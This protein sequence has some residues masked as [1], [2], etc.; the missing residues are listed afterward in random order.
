MSV[1]PNDEVCSELSDYVFN[2]YIDDE[3]TLPPNIW[4]KE[5]MFDPR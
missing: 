2:N 5:P 4:A 1:C 3:Y